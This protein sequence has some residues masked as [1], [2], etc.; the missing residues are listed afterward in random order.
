ML[1][2]LIAGHMIGD[3]LLQNKWMAEN[4][5]KKLSALLVHTAVY[6][7]AVWVASQGA[8]GLRWLGILLI[9]VSHSLLDNRKFVTWWCKYITR[10]DPAIYLAMMTD[11]AWHIVVLMLVCLF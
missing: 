3:Y 5:A 1:A 6:T 7:V 8:G 4:K 11:Q 10:S 9:F 2:W